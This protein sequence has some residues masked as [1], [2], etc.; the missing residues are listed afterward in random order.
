MVQ[1]CEDLVANE[2][3][4]PVDLVVL[5]SLQNVLSV[6]VADMVE[7]GCIRVDGDYFRIRLRASD[8]ERRRRFTLAHEI[9]HIFFETTSLVGVTDHEVGRYGAKDEVEYLCDL[10][11]AEVL[12][13]RA[14][15]RS[16]CPSQ[17][18][19][20]DV[21]AMA[22]EF[23]A[24]LEA[25]ASRIVGLGLGP[26]Q[27]VVLEPRLTAAQE[28]SVRKSAAAPSFVGME[29]ANPRR[30][31]RVAWSTGREWFVP[32]NKSANDGTALAG[33]IQAG[34]VDVVEDPGITGGRPVRVVGRHLPYWRGDIW[35]DRVMA[36]LYL[37]D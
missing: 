36:F 29:A 30:R 10:G 7:A 16:R 21:C 9:C 17:P 23:D 33:C 15:F 31:L 3:G 26:A 27:L 34:D 28:R 2:P 25:T 24:S 22:E 11:A 13:P 12:L 8:S 37:I 6:E 20:D 19:F 5:A 35:V 14:A 32:Q 18:G 4:V 1:M